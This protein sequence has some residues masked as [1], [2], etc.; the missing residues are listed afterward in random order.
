MRLDNLYVYYS[1][2]LRCALAWNGC[3]LQPIRASVFR[4]VSVE[5]QGKRIFQ[6]SIPFLPK[7]I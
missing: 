1:A 7:G 2:Q 4:L 5:F 3:A 6:A